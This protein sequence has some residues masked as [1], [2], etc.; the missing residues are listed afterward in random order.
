MSRTEVERLRDHCRA[1]LLAA[2][3]AT[4]VWRGRLSPS[5]LATAV[6]A[7]TLRRTGADADAHA[8]G[9]GEEWLA[10]TILA[11]GSWGDTPLSQGN[12]STTLLALAC[13][14]NSP[15]AEAAPAARRAE[16]WTQERTGALDPDRIA[17]AVLAHYGDDRTFSVPILSLCAL[18]GLLGEAPQCWRRIPQLPFELATLPRATFAVLGLPV[19]SYA[20]PALIALGLVRHRCGPPSV[21]PWRRLAESAV[22]RRLERIQ[23]ASGGFLEAVPLSGFVAMSLGAAGFGDHAV[24]HRCLGFLRRAQRDDGSWAIDSDLATWLTT[25]SVT[26]LG[27]DLPGEARSRLVQWLL[28]QQFQSVHPYTGAAAGGWAWTDLPGGVPDADDTA[29]ALLALHRLGPAEAERTPAAEA[30]LAW[31]LALTNRD[32]GVPTFC[33]GWGRMPFDRSCPDIT[34]HALRAFV[35]WQPAVS[36]TLQSRLCAAVASGLAYLQ[37]AQRADGS[38][39]PLWFGNE[40]SPAHGNPVYGTARVL[41]AIAEVLPAAAVATPAWVAR[42]LAWLVA[43]QRPEGGWGGDCGVDASVE[44]TALAVGALTH[45]PAGQAAAER[46]LG[47]LLRHPDRL[48]QPAPIGLYFASLWY[49]EELYPLIFATEAL[50]GWLAER[51]AEVPACA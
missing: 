30:G 51:S 36:R 19:V 45:W 18:G 11:D 10:R 22:L 5:A 38:W 42:A 33:R 49:Y 37:Q 26:A 46:G 31:L 3:D 44:E 6:A 41:L 8:A 15:L 40:A 7:F 21:I 9:Q 32:G 25:L 24:T 27:E 14:R 34:A 16:A 35:R 43:A 1:R 39:L 28:G 17:G 2:R 12:L 4:G 23:P 47:W 48:D 29:G 50:S 13:L 20:L